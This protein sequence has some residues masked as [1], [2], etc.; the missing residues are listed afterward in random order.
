[1]EILNM[2]D[3]QFLEKLSAALTVNA[4]SVKVRSTVL[5]DWAQRFNIYNP[6]NFIDPA[7]AGDWYDATENFE[8]FDTP[9]VDPA[10]IEISSGVSLKTNAGEQTLNLTALST[11]IAE[12]DKYEKLLLE[13]FV[14]Y[15][16]LNGGAYAAGEHFTFAMN[17]INTLE[18]TNFTQETFIK[19][20]VQLREIQILNEAGE[21]RFH[22]SV[23]WDEEHGIYLTEKNG[24]IVVIEL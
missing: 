22:F 8:H 10:V 17:S 2:D 14:R 4:D 6:E 1:M 11:F 20:L 16:F 18:S 21:L 23:A 12:K 3:A 13:F 7:T 5:P 19:N 9:F 15:T 24:E